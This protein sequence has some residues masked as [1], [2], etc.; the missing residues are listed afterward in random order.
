M[1]SANGSVNGLL[2]EGAVVATG[3]EVLA[4]LSR[5]RSL[6]VY[7]AW[8]LE[9]DCRCV[10]KVVRPD[11]HSPRA[12]R[13][14]TREG[15]LLLELTHPH[16]VRA[17]ELRRRPRTVL[18]LETLSGE[19]L[20]HMSEAGRRRLAIADVAH[21]G[22]QL[23][24]AIGYLH[25]RGYL[26]LDLKPANVIVQG[27]QAKVIDLSLARHPGPVPRGRGTP[28]YLSPEQARGGSVGPAA[29]V[30]GIGATLYEAATRER[31]FPDARRGNY[32]Q[33]ERRAPTVGD[34]RRAPGAFGS[35]VDA[36]LSHEPSDRPTVA[37]LADALDAVV[38]D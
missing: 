31:P 14:L 19:T 4:H 28:P 37:E 3:Y 16:L 35:L 8:S 29:D 23:C 13:R 10:A 36:C 34:R 9:R 27:G 21:L 33:L 17:Y 6:D 11:Q 26:H 38:G 2:A 22:L 15:E 20:E 5:G 18:I 30:W 7:D 24:S 12:R 1:S 32:P 25:G